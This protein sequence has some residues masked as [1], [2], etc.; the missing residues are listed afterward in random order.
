MSDLSS[1]DLDAYC[2]RIG[3][4]GPRE[5][6]LAVLSAV[7]ALQP[8]A[9][10]FENLDPLLHRPVPLDLASLQAKL[11]A[12]RRGGYCFELNALFHA[13][14]D[15]LGFAVTPL[16]GRVRWMAP[17]DHPEGPRNH[18]LLRVDLE[19]GAYLA[20]AAFGG[21]LVSAPLR[22]E[23]DIEQQAPASRLRLQA[24]GPVFTLQTLLPGGWQDVYRFTL[25][26]AYPADYEI[27]NWFTSTH[28]ESIF[29]TFLIAERLTPEARYTLV[30]R[31]LTERRGGEVKARGIADAGEL[32]VVLET[33]FGLVPP[34]PAEA[35]WTRLPQD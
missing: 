21:H 28:P 29:R 9:I 15:A 23:A 8:A 10:P 31:T 5:P 7:H 26:P 12:G 33:V 32:G 17:P 24:D 19:E 34:E 22:L 16:I 3:Y 6:T 2:A 4:A 35:I 18:M 30:N 20:D 13:A 11:V 25:E 14:L 1:F 27:S